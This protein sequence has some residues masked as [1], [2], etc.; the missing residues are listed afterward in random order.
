MLKIL[1]FGL[2]LLLTQAQYTVVNSDV[3]NSYIKL[4]LRYS[5]SQDYYVKPKSKIIKELVF[6]FQALT[7]N[8]FT[9]KIY[10]PNN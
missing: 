8:E 10:D 5:G 3:G 2:C 1:L 6:Y 9:F 7:Y 4:S